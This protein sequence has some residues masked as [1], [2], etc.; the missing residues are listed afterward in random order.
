M[1]KLT[2]WVNGVRGPLW[3]WEERA[4]LRPWASLSPGSLLNVGDPSLPTGEPA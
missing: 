1:K 3:S 2:M 4:A